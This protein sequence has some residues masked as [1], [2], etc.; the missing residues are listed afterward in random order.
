MNL[1]IKED[2]ASEVVEYIMKHGESLKDELDLTLV[3]HYGILSY[4]VNDAMI[5]ELSHIVA[6]AL[7]M[8]YGDVRDS[9][10]MCVDKGIV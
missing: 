6:R 9:V 5:D 8:S 4:E 1:F 2:C 3:K 10:K 7:N